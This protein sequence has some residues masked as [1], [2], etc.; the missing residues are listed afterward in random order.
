MA[1]KANGKWLGFANR[2]LDNSARTEIIASPK[3]SIKRF[4]D[5]LRSADGGPAGCGG[6][7]LGEQTKALP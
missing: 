7:N 1:R 5:G 4:S 2:V 3:S 6:S